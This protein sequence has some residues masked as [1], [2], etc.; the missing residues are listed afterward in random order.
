M[1]NICW[2]LFFSCFAVWYWTLLLITCS[3][4]HAQ[5]DIKKC[6]VC[7][8]RC[9][10]HDGLIIYNYMWMCIVLDFGTS[11]GVGTETEPV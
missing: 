7:V 11:Q 10:M 1:A 6:Y 3:T 9:H 5:I 8:K 4:E 2:T